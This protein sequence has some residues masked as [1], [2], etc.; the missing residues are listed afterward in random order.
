[1]YWF[2]RFCPVGYEW[3]FLT[4]VTLHWWLTIPMFFIETWNLGRK[5]KIKAQPV[6]IDSPARPITSGKI[7][8][9]EDIRP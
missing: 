9:W 3:T 4:I 1:M 5:R 7:T 2:R 8:R 6:T